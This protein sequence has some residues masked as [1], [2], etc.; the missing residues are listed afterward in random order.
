MAV[1]RIVTDV[2]ALPLGFVNAFFIDRDGLTL[3]DTGMY[4]NA[5]RILAAVQELGQ[6]P[7]DTRHIL[8]THLHTDHTGSLAAIKQATGAKVC[9]HA[10]DASLI[11][12]GIAGRSA[13]APTGPF[14]YLVPGFHQAADRDFTR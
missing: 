12:Q 14:Q 3:I 4:G 13:Y 7:S 10:A 8:V 5:G 1:K 6:Q 9:M 11:R 2:Y